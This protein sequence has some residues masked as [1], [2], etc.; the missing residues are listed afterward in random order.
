MWSKKCKAKENLQECEVKW[1]Q[2]VPLKKILLKNEQNLS[3]IDSN[4]F[5]NNF[6]ISFLMH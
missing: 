3:H 4:W 2:N 1:T 6:A 5:A